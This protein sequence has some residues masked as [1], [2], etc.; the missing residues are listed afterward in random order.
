MDFLGSSNLND[1]VFL[2][3][4]YV[5]L[6]GVIDNFKSFVLVMIVFSGW[7]MHWFLTVYVILDC[8]VMGFCEEMNCEL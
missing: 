1:R 3:Q 5:L 7:D 8:C 2:S 4:Q 6:W